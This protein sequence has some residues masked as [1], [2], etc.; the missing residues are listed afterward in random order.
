MDEGP[1]AVPG[2]SP[3]SLTTSVNCVRVT[4]RMMMN[5]GSVQ[6]ASP[7]TSSDVLAPV[8][9]TLHVTTTSNSSSGT[10]QSV[11]TSVALCVTTVGCSSTTATT[12]AEHLC[13]LMTSTSTAVCCQSCVTVSST[14]VGGVS[15]APSQLPS[16]TVRGRVVTFSEC[17]TTNGVLDNSDDDED[18]HRDTSSVVLAST[19]T[20][21]LATFANVDEPRSLQRSSSNIELSPASSGVAQPLNNN[22]KDDIQKVSNSTFSM[23]G[24]GVIKENVASVTTLING[25]DG[26]AS[27]SSHATRPIRRSRPTSATDQHG[28]AKQHVGWS[29]KGVAV[30]SSAYCVGK[31]P[32]P[33]PTRTSSV[34]TRGAAAA[35]SVTS[36]PARPKSLQAKVNGHLPGKEP[37]R[38]TAPPAPRSAS[39]QQLSTINNSLS[40]TSAFKRDKAS[41]ATV[42]GETVEDLT[43]TEIN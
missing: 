13:V 42:T 31:V 7:A 28:A 11:V 17:P 38:A 26:V 19:L 36:A 2:S 37:F 27:S 21:N 25:S 3:R 20:A 1:A 34:L 15:R 39:V 35:R 12:T 43:E 22:D 29:G 32:P 30:T 8:S 16:P 6:H 4:E 41:P 33:V 18:T 23:P 24:D 5:G 10:R 40:L 9:V 14:A